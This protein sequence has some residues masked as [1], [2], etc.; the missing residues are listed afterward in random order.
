MRRLTL[1]VLLT[2]VLLLASCSALKKQV[3]MRMTGADFL[4]PEPATSSYTD[5]GGGGGGDR[6]KLDQRGRA[7]SIASLPDKNS[8]AMPRMIVRSG[9]LAIVSD[10]P[11]ET[12]RRVTELAHQLGGYVE[13]ASVSGR[14][15]RAQSADM[16]LRVPEEKLDSAREQIKKLAKYVN[17]DSVEAT[18]V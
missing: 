6:D 5:G 13:K 11:Q 16:V 4:A 2:P 10:D 1:V 17:Q 7:Q 14:E 12:V 9:T 3:A 18:D 15:R 8:G